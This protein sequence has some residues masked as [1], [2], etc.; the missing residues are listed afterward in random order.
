MANYIKYINM[1]KYMEYLT[2][3]AK[4]TEYHINIARY[5]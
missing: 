5:T 2:K 1:A 3:I 4:Y